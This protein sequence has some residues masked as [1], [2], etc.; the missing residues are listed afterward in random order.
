MSFVLAQPLGLLALSALPVIV[1]LHRYVLRAESREVSNL[2]L[3]Q[4]RDQATHEGRERRKV[5]DKLVLGLELSA[6][7]ALVLVLA[8]FDLP[9]P[10]TA[11]ARVAL[12]VDGSA[13]MAGGEGASKPIARARALLAELAR[14]SSSLAVT[15]I[16]AGESAAV[17][18][19]PDLTPEAADAQL[20]VFTPRAARAQLTA[21][22]ALAAGLGY[23]S[24]STLILSDDA[25]QQG[26]RVLHVGQRT[27]NTAI[28]H[29]SW[30]L[31][32]APFIA[33]RR[34]G[35]ANT[36][37]L[38]II[39]DEGRERSE[40]TLELAADSELPLSIV[41][42]DS[43]QRVE[44]RLAP[45]AL[46]IDDNA[47]LLRPIARSLRLHDQTHTPLLTRA[48]ARLQ[49][50]LPVLEASPADRAEWTIVENPAANL[51]SAALGVVTRA[52]KP[53][54][55]VRA[56]APDPFSPLLA[57]FDAR[58]LVWYAFDLPP[59]AAA[60][61]LLR[62]GE[63]PLL[64]RQGAM[65][66]LNVDVARSNLLEHAAFPVLFEHI[67]SEL[68]DA[69]TGLLRSNYAQSESLRFRRAPSWRGAVSVQGPSGQRWSFAAAVSDIE[70]GVAPEPGVYK[71]E[72]SAGTLA[73]AVQFAA[74]HES[75]LTQ[76]AP[77]NPAPAL[78]FSERRGA[79]VGSRLRNWL[80]L[81]TAL[82]CVAVYALLQRRAAPR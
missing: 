14:R 1:W 27:A 56:W 18:G 13:S 58:G 42:P 49:H 77:E 22:Q 4:E 19:K 55:L 2:R 33:V 72:T 35:P 24:A 28:V 75:D 26:V 5:P 32:A 37:Q 3:W 73:F 16:V 17:L 38:Q 25:E 65:L 50:A 54:T 74:A 34:F 61:V 69:Q 62:D 57:D 15:V 76:R 36:V 30:Q 71:V 8:G 82:C 68:L 10:S 47:V 52:S 81:A 7:T 44:L 31:G 39:V 80:L 46:R 78:S 11:R 12:I 79:E 20:A 59:W 66:M 6:A 51:A 41:V 64:W 9:A 40:R 60:Q 53:A 23:P 21:A 67:V 48:I 63:R 45:D 70:L 43:T 29:A